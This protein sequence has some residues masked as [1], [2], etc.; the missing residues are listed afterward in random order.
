M[1][2]DRNWSLL[3]GNPA[4]M[5]AALL[6]RAIAYAPEP[7]NEELWVDLSGNEINAKSTGT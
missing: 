6:L 2:F 1:Y 7:R 3:G 4:L 5:I